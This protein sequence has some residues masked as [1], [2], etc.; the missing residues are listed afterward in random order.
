MNMLAQATDLPSVPAELLKWVLTILAFIAVLGL[1]FYAALKKP[2]KM[3]VRVDDEPAIKV[4]KTARRYNHDA[5]ELRFTNIE[6]TVS[7]HGHE[8]AKIKELLRVDLPSMERRLESSNEVRAARIH[9]HIE[10]DRKELDKK[11]DGQFDRVLATLRN[12]GKI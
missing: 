1:A 8:I 11:I 3:K 5:S 7:E 12:M 10:N 4:E 6:E 2:E 9:E